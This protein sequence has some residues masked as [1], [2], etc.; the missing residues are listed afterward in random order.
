[1]MKTLIVEYLPGYPQS[2]TV[3]LLERFLDGVPAGEQINRR[4]LLAT[5]P[6]LF[7]RQSLQAY[8]KRDLLGQATTA[9]EAAS[10]AEFDHLVAEVKAA[11]VLV[12]A[13]PMHNFSLPASV[14]AYFDAIMLN[15]GTWRYGPGDGQYTG[16]MTGRKALTLSAAGGLYLDPPNPWDHLTTLARVELGFMGFTEIE[17]VLAEGMMREA[18]VRQ[19]SLDRCHAEIT[20][21]V[22]RWYGATAVPAETSRV[23]ASGTAG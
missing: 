12:L 3:T 6:P 4:D 1:M 5:P 23:H 11:D 21:I 15:H 2:H 19:A 18:A 10:L 17:T 20:A 16:L 14:K 9:A 7:S 22:D 13:F 8:T